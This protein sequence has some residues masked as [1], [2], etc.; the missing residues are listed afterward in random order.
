MN[1]KTA[2]KRMAISSIVLAGALG[3]TAC[4][5]ED[6]TVTEPSAT[7]SESQG[8]DEASQ[9]EE[10][11]SEEESSETS[12]S[13]ESSET[14]EESP[15]SEES[16]SGSGGSDS[17]PTEP[18][19]KDAQ[20]KFGEPAVIEDDT[21]GN[22]RLTVD[23]LEKAPDSVYSNTRLNKSDGT[24]YFIKFRVAPVSEGSSSASFRASSVNGLFMF[25]TFDASQ[26]A[27]RMY[28]S[29]DGCKTDSSKELAIGETGEGCYIYQVSGKD[30]TTVSYKT[31][32]YNLLWQ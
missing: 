7:Q 19:A 13:S 28:G 31:S 6:T 32:Q 21:K 27:K 8:S 18:S 12:E 9:S 17:G 22:F 4:N 14:S 23:K 11:P 10:S 1:H 5:S 16:E 20:M 2:R 30:A 24:V 29:V 26:K 25:P 15:S 3:L